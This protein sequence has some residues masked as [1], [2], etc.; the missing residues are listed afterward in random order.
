MSGSDEGEWVGGAE[1]CVGDGTVEVRNVESGVAGKGE[2]G[3]RDWAEM[4][5]TRTSIYTSEIVGS[6]R[7][8]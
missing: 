4:G 1:W 8:V 3:R 7:C 5:V 2:V 6:V